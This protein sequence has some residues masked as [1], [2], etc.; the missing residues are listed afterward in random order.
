MKKIISTSYGFIIAVPGFFVHLYLAVDVLAAVIKEKAWVGL[1]LFFLYFGLAVGFEL[2]FN[3]TTTV[4]WIDNGVVK[5]RGLIHGFYKEC[6]ISDIQAVK[7]VYDHK[8]PF[9]RHFITLVDNVERQFNTIE[10]SYI[11]F[12]KTDANLEF[13]KTFWSG[14]IERH[15]GRVE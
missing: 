1:L 12:V 10:N 14:K 5:S 2:F 7:I 11:R 4:I 3:L 9:N 6:V 8:E 13:V 15:N